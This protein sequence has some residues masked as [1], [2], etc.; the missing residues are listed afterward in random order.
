MS[1]EQF[2]SWMLKADKT[3]ADIAYESKLAPRTIYNFLNGL[4]VHRSTKAALSNYV[5]SVEAQR[6]PSK[7]KAASG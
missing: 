1:V 2:K 6:L 3:V 4:R 5:A 7:A